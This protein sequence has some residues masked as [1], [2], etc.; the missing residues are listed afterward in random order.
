MR[1]PALFSSGVKQVTGRETVAPFHFQRATARSRLS[2]EPIPK[3][4]DLR[5]TEDGKEGLT[6]VWESQRSIEAACS[7]RMEE[8]LNAFIPFPTKQNS[9]TPRCLIQWTIRTLQ[10]QAGIP[11]GLPG[12]LDPLKDG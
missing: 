4:G 6:G 10:K 9:Q 1:D 11:Q 7:L 5:V 3:P 8:S 12:P 2:P